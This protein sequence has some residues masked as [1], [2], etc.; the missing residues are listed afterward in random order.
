[1]ASR[2]LW[3]FMSARTRRSLALSWSALFVLSLLMQYFNFAL[4][5]PVSAAVGPSLFELDGNAV[6]SNSAAVAGDDWD[7]SSAGPRPA[8]SAL[9]D[10][11]GFNAGDDI[12]TG[13]NTKDIDNITLW[14]WKCGIV[15]DKDDIENAFAAAYT[16][17]AQ[18]LRLLRP[19]PLPDERRRHRRLLVPE[20]RDRQGRNG[21]HGSFTGAHANGDILVVLDFSNGGAIATAKIYTWTT[22]LSSPAPRARTAT[23][24]SRTSARSLTRPPSRRPWTYDDKGV[25]GAD[26]DFPANALFEGGIDL[27]ALG[28]RHGLLLDIPRRD[29]LLEHDDVDPVRLRDGSFSFCVPPDHRDAG[30]AGRPEHGL[31]R[32]HHDRR[33]GH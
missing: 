9:S 15:Q 28:T 2:G 27:T 5:A 17:G 12:F 22:A 19:G 33:L 3:H 7:R 18:H 6:D 11:D 1:M 4:A 10:H 31:Q 30:Q 26:N 20:E 29:A 32:P 25:A 24:P 16:S 14:L 13:G 21:P 23:A 8:D